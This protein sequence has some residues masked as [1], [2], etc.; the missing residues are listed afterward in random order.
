MSTDYVFA[1]SSCR[2][3]FLPSP[4]ILQCEFCDAPLDI[5]YIQPYIATSDNGTLEAPSPLEVR[6]D[7]FSLGEGNTPIITLPNLSN[8]LGIKLL[9]KNEA[10]NPTG[11]FKDRG[12][13]ILISCL[14]SFGIKEIVEDSS[15]NAGSSIS[16]YS[17]AAGIKAHIFA[18]ETAPQPKI[19]QIKVYGAIHHPVAG[20]RDKVMEVAKKYAADNNLTYA[21]HNLSPYFIEGTKSF[22][23]ELMSD[24]KYMFPSDI[25]I[26][27]GNGSLYI[28]IYKAMN[29]LLQSDHIERMPRMHFVQ[30]ES[31]K[32]IASAVR[33]ETWNSQMVSTTKAGGIAVGSPP[34]I[35]QVIDIMKTSGGQCDTVQENEIID[36]QLKLAKLEGIYSEP[37]SAAAFAGTLKL[38]QSGKIPKDSTVL[39]P[40]TGSGL[41][42]L[43]PV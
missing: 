9:T 37:T 17:A 38:I 3:E 5:K 32:P 34:R 39:V 10:Q 6:S 27:V 40:I 31:V 21:S 1:C 36:W 24:R 14:R 25:V 22:G 8:L 19:N 20:S 16:A 43:S 26:P 15:G 41:K 11:S 2:E 28:G 4:A 42:D 12:T 23:Y 13:S 30:A 29:E 18:P 33:N 7:Q 35:D